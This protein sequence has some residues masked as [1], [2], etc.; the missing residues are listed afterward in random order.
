MHNKS[1]AVTLHL[2][3]SPN[4]KIELS[5]LSWANMTWCDWHV[6]NERHAPDDRHAHRDLIFRIESAPHLSVSELRDTKY[7]KKL[8]E[9]VGGLLRFI[10]P[11]NSK[12]NLGVE[13]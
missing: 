5:R 4:N 13:F 12:W 3:L 2:D 1:A 6:M 11:D 8:D 10:P 9:E 7:L